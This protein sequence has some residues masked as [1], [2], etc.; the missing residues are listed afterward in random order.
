MIKLVRI[1]AGWLIKKSNWHKAQ[2]QFMR[3]KISKN[4][5]E[6]HAVGKLL[7]EWCKL[8]KVP[9]ELVKP[10]GKINAKQFKLITGY[11]NSTNQEKR[12]AG[13][14]VWNYNK[15]QITCRF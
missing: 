1:E 5:G 8:N 11:D 15:M 2:G 12:D 7:T 14:L 6:N 4:V 10:L 13:M 9:F 3:E